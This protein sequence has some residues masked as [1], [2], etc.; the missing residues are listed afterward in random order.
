MT[1]IRYQSDKL[2]VLFLLI[3]AIFWYGLPIEG[4]KTPLLKGTKN[5]YPE[6]VITPNVP[7]ELA[8]KA[9]SFGDKQFYFRTLAFE[10]Q[11]AGD[12]Y[13]RFT[14]LKDY[15]YEKL[16]QWFLLLDT[17]DYRSNFTPALAS[18]I[19]SQT[20][21]TPDVKYIVEYL[22]HHAS[23]DLQNKWWWMSQAV[24]LA[25]HK[26]ENKEWA[27]ELA[28]KLAS[29]PNKDMPIWARQMPAFLHEDLGEKQ[30]A[31]AIIQ[32]LAQDFDNL[33]PG[34]VNFMNY[35]IQER[36]GMLKESVEQLNKLNEMQKDE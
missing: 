19:F 4:L 5:I 7:N 27:L 11:N 15:D 24:Y 13:G 12:T 35:F 25:R 1:I 17:L 9:L 30:A 36:L 2:L 31:L 32:A 8:V 3:Q 10:I 29:S 23:Q 14:P 28:Y 16:K 21:H 20:Q 6:M 22:D 33:K 18:Y 34:E 26:L